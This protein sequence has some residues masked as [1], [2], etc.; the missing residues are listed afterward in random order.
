MI[1]LGS[2]E[3]MAVSLLVQI[4][5]SMSLTLD[6][7]RYR[8]R[9]PAGHTAKQGFHTLTAETAITLGLYRHTVHGACHC[10]RSLAYIQSVAVRTLLLYCVR[11]I[12][13][14]LWYR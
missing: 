2:S 6:Q 10:Y 4:A 9:M 5:E 8:A 11:F 1:V 12:C 14:G 7:M 13:T 3:G